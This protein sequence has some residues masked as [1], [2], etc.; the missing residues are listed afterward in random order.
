MPELV[1]HSAQKAVAI[2]VIFKGGRTQLVAEDMLMAF[3]L[4]IQ[5]NVYVW[6]QALKWLFRQPAMAFLKSKSYLRHLCAMAGCCNIV[7]LMAVNMV[8]TVLCLSDFM[9]A[10]GYLV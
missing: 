6:A 7:G 3:S 8:R 5:A 10:T 4:L 1:C 2:Y 9:T